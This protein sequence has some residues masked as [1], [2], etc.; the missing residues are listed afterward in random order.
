[1]D[2]EFLK[3][4]QLDEDKWRIL[5]IPFGGPYAEKDM[6]GQFFTGKTDIKPH[7]F[8]TRPVVFHHG[9]DPLLKDTDFGEQVLEDEPEEAVG[10]WSQIWLD[11]SAKYWDKVNGLLKRGK[12]YGSSGA[13]GHFVKANNTTGEILV[14]P[15]AEQTLTPI[16]INFYSRI[17]ATKAVADL[18]AITADLR[19]DLLDDGDPDT[20]DLTEGGEDAAMERLALRLKA[21]EVRLKVI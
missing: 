12:M 17:T 2:S 7:W 5:A 15:H 19:P 8:K 16:P 4:E 13:L 21:L 10:W 11:R 1:M 3:A 6:Q 20:G 14:W 18:E 9:K